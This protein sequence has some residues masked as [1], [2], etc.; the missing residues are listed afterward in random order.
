MENAILFLES[1]QG[2]RK[3]AATKDIEAA[4]QQYTNLIS[5]CIH[6]HTYVQGYRTASIEGLSPAQP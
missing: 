5:S 2:L 3:A 1:V 4:R 6:C